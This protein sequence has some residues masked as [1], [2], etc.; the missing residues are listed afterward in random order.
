[1]IW[2]RQF[3]SDSNS[4]AIHVSDILE[5]IQRSLVLCNANRP[6]SETRREIALDPYLKR[7][8]KGE[9]AGAK[10][11]LFRQEFKDTLV[12]KVEADSRQ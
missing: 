1:M 11:D 6:I 3:K 9:F 7:Y 8:G 4:D 2:N 12:K 5:T 10:A